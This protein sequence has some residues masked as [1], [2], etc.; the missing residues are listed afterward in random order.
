[1][2]ACG[3]KFSRGKLSLPLDRVTPYG[4]VWIEIKQL[5]PRSA[6]R[7][8]TPYGG[9]WIEIP[10]MYYT[11]LPA[12]SRLMEACGLK[13]SIRK[14]SFVSGCHALWRRVD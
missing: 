3:L 8:V 12:Q 10:W 4:G 14:I 13:Y 5:I 2:E 9:V 1:M 7:K 6:F 11:M